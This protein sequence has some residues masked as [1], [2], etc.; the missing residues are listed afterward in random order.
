MKRRLWLAALVVGVAAGAGIW[1]VLRQRPPELIAVA[2]PD[3]GGVEPEVRR[4][5]EEKRAQLANAPGAAE[6][7]RELGVAY[8]AHEFRDPAGVCYENAG[9]LDPAAPRWPG[10]LAELRWEQGRT[11]EADQAMTRAEGLS[12]RL[13]HSDPTALAA[14]AAFLG[15]TSRALGRGDAA[16]G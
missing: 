12:R 10:L 11:G 16:M 2:H 7:W 1:G 6:A 4:S 8:H 14:Q 5:I 13:A 3:L 15:D 9:R